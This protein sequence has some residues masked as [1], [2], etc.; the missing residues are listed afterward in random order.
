M[1]IN[2][3]LEHLAEILIFSN[4][5]DI[6]RYYYRITFYKDFLQNTYKMSLK[7]YGN[8][9]IEIENENPKFKFTFVRLIHWLDLFI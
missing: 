2:K 8:P 4:I 5:L 3:S 9:I 6:S 7:I 1:I